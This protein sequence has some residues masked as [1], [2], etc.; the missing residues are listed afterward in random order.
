MTASGS[1]FVRSTGVIDSMRQRFVGERDAHVSFAIVRR[2]FAGYLRGADCWHLATALYLAPNP[3]D[4][5]FLTLDDT[6]RKI[7]KTL[8]FRT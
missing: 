5:T 7:A 8:G 4:L 3:S 2:R 6:Q 1:T